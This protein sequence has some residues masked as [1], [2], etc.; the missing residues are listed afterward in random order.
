MLIPRLFRFHLEAFL[1]TSLSPGTG[2]I[3]PV[4]LYFTKTNYM[5]IL[6]YWTV[7]A[8]ANVLVVNK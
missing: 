3:V 8:F 4:V 1:T 6:S 5:L 7:S 2:P